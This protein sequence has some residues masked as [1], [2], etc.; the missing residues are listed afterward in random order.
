MK[1]K[2]A[3]I[4]HNALQQWFSYSTALGPRF[5]IGYKLATQH[6]QQNVFDV[7]WGW[8]ICH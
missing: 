7:F 6:A 4:E 3:G 5:Y 8:F 2:W 1:R